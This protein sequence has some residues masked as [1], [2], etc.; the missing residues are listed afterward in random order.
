ME[1]TINP[2]LVNLPTKDYRSLNDFQENLKVL[3]KVNYDKLRKS[4]EEKGL[5]APFFLWPDP[6]TNKDFIIDGHQRKRVFVLEKVQPFEVPY[7]YVPGETKEEAKQN[8][9]IITSQYGRVT[10]QGF[11]E[12]VFDLPEQWVQ[13]TIH[14]DA[15]SKQMTASMAPALSA[16]P[17]DVELKAYSRTHVLISFPPDKLIEIQDL[18]NQIIEKPYVEYEQ[19]SN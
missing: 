10:E 6:E 15:L 2:N 5:L 1:I 16:F 9:L 17:E 4:L 18:L 12:F 13:S 14:M 3:E 8:L 7:I 11:N 19:G